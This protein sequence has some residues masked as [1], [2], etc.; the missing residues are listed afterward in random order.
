MPTWDGKGGGIA[1]VDENIVMKSATHLQIE[2]NILHYPNIV[3]DR[4]R[5]TISGQLHLHLQ[6]WETGNNKQ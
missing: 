3:F 6:G 4:P 5:Q 2:R 1:S